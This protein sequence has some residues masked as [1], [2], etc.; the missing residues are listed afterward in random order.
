MRSPSCSSAALDAM[1]APWSSSSARHRPSARLTSSSSACE[2]CARHSGRR[3]RASSRTRD[4]PSRR[5]AP[6]LRPAAALRAATSSCRAPLRRPAGGLV[7]LLLDLAL[8]RSAS[9]RRGLENRLALGF[10]LEHGGI[11]GIVFGPGQELLRHG[12]ARLAA[13]ACGPGNCWYSETTSFW[14][15][16]GLGTGRAHAKSAVNGNGYRRIAANPRASRRPAS[17]A[18][19]PAAAIRARR[20]APLRQTRP[21]RLDGHSMSHDIS[22]AAASVKKATELSFRNYPLSSHSLP[23]RNRVSACPRTSSRTPSRSGAR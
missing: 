5:G 15:V 13:A 2:P 12:L 10:A 23:R 19:S 22:A 4:A 8:A 9:R 16:S 20:R 18:G 6:P 17:A 14:G 1:T 3:V 7:G 21:S 11:G